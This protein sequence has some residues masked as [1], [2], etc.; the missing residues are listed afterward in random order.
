[1]RP[2]EPTHD[3]GGAFP[4]DDVSMCASLSALVY[5]SAEHRVWCSARQEPERPRINDLPVHLRRAL[6][7]SPPW[8]LSPLPADFDARKGAASMCDG[9]LVEASYDSEAM[10]LTCEATRTI[11][12][13]FRGTESVSDVLVDL[14]ISPIMRAPGSRNWWS[15]VH[16]GFALAYRPMRPLLRKAVQRLLQQS[17]YERIIVTGHSLGG[18]L[19]TLCAFDLARLCNAS[20][21]THHQASRSAKAAEICLFTFGSPRVG[22][23]TFVKEFDG[24][25]GR[26]FRFVN[27]RDIVPTG[28]YTVMGFRH[29]SKLVSLSESGLWLDPDSEAAGAELTRRNEPRKTKLARL[30]ERVSLDTPSAYV[31]R[32]TLATAH[33]PQRPNRATP[34]SASPTM[35]STRATRH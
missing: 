20:A 27:D 32:L 24:L 17:K 13:V 8:Q 22:N 33:R 10:L 9:I 23:G 7:G 31:L 4:F 6:S 16:R 15:R 11:V 26:S 21:K 19:A 30:K 28:P 35:T 3:C 12:I 34:R 25:V 1:M 14:R 5:F 2:P 29:V 18:A